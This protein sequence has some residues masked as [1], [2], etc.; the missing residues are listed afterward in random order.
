MPFVRMESR[1]WSKCGDVNVPSFNQPTHSNTCVIINV[2]KGVPIC[3]CGCVEWMSAVRALT[4]DPFPFV[5]V[6]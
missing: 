4:V 2:D 6:T 3:K 1:G 5:P